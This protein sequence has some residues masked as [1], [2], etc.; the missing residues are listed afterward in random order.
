VTPWQGLLCH[1]HPLRAHS[2]RTLSI[3]PREARCPSFP[4]ACPWPLLC[5]S[6]PTQSS[7]R[8]DN[9]M[10]P[11]LLPRRFLHCIRHRPLYNTPV[12]AGFPFVEV[13]VPFQ[14]PPKV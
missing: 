5:Y 13:P 9:E 14:Q 7:Y 12:T 1:V 6:Q 8:D 2:S 10:P 11:S 4:K 3:S